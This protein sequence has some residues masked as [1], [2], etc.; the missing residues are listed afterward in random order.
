[1]SPSAARKMAPSMSLDLPLQSESESERAQRVSRYFEGTG[2][3]YDRVVQVTTLGQ[4]TRWKRRLMARIPPGS[5]RVL[6]L[7]CGTGIVTGHLLR[8]CPR[9][10]ITGVDLTPEYLAI[11]R[12]RF[13]GSGR[14]LRFVLGNAETMTFEG[15]F[16]AIVSS[17]LPKYVHPRQLL[18]GLLPHLEPGAAIALHD[19]TYPRRPLQQQAWR[20]WM[21]TIQ[22]VGLRIFPQWRAALGGDL[23]DLIRA[24]RWSSEYRWVLRDLGFQD[25]QR[26]WITAQ[27]AAV[28]SARWPG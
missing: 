4:D 27:M 16:D 22:H 28:V 24:S 21:K 17:Y 18:T 12:R 3:S 8:R 25:I 5:R 11:A 26:E 13:E 14:A 7:A 15:T 23:A 6:D 20:A 1:M 10:R 9:A 2:S 19:F